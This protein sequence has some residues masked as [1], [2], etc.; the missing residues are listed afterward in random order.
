MLSRTNDETDWKRIVA[1]TDALAAIAPTP[2]V[3]LNRAVA[4][5][6][7][8]GPHA[9]LEL[10]EALTGDPAL[11]AYPYLPSIRGD[12]LMKTGRYNDARIE[13]ERAA[14]L[15]KNAQERALLT[16]RAKAMLVSLSPRP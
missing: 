6:M 13:F 8:Y 16:A 15:S 1:R 4:V 11:R 7:A 9:G 14:E 5:G 12:L 2:V 3:E 10:V